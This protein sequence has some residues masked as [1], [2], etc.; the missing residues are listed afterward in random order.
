MSSYNIGLK[1]LK[2]FV[3]DGNS[4]AYFKAKLTPILFKAGPELELFTVV[5]EH[6]RSYQS[7]PDAS[8][9]VGKFPEFAEIVAPET[10]KYYLDLLE[11]RFCYDVINRAN[12]ASQDLLKTDKNNTDK[13]IVVLEEAI[14][15]I[16]AQRFRIK[17]LDMGTEGLSLLLGTY[18]NTLTS[19]N[20][21]SM[22]GWAYMDE[23]T[24]GGLPGDVISVVG[25]PA[26]GKSW[27][28]LYIALF[29]WTSRN[30]NILFVSMEMNTLSIAQRI[31]AMYAGTNITQLK[32]AGYSS[33]TFEIFLTGMDKMGKETSKFYVVDGNLAAN[34]EDIYTLCK[35][36][37]CNV[38]FID[39]AYLVRHKNPKLDRFTKVA[40]NVELMKRYTTE[41]EV[42]TF[43]SWQFSRE[44][45]KKT[46]QKGGK[47]DLEDIGYS[48]AIGQVSSIVLGLMQ[49]EGVETIN[50]R[51]IDVLKGRNGEVGKFSVK[52]DFVG[53]DFSQYE[54]EPEDKQLDFI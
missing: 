16:V 4:F 35:Q 32:S 18:H 40:E 21:P 34:V 12:I 42:P 30:Q 11:N 44:A 9:V 39:G 2:R 6:F 5:D 24:G 31:A 14:G 43:A 26:Q 37:H 29:N 51:D 33:S 36:L 49:E 22:F 50:K 54:E 23:R 48:D 47:P 41:L 28:L 7:L 45:V 53:M 19:E 46:K 8:T 52:W 27:F 15:A 1:A 3:E 20:P 25:R 13:A 38:V 10:P 17:L